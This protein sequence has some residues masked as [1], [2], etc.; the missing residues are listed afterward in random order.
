M[1]IC[2]MTTLAEETHSELDPWIGVMGGSWRKWELGMML[3][4]DED[5]VRKAA[6]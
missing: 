1:V 5:Q 3:R 2:E 4:A 6:L